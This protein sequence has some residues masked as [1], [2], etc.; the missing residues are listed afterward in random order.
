M[1][2]AEE[3]HSDDRR[4]TTPPRSPRLEAAHAG[5]CAAVVVAD[6]DQPRAGRGQCV[7]LA[8]AM[9]ARIRMIAREIAMRQ[10]RHLRRVHSARSTPPAA[11][12]SAAARA[13]VTSPASAPVASAMRALAASCSSPMSTERA[14]RG[15]HRLDH[16]RRHDSGAAQPRQRAGGIDAATDA[17]AAA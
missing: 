11:S 3:A 13:V 16:F 5:A 14:R 15:G 7:G 1:A 9:G 2:L 10:R 4:A 12:V 17:E 6:I 8:R